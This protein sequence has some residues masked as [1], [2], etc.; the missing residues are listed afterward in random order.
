MR[1]LHIE[2]IVSGYRNEEKATRVI[3]NRPDM[4]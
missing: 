4:S 2:W 1:E 3:M